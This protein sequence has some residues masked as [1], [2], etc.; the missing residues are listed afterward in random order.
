MIIVLAL[1]KFS[2]DRI[3]AAIE[4]LFIWSHDVKHKPKYS[5]L[6]TKPE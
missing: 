3:S 6:Q 5:S 1:L 4:Q 2:V